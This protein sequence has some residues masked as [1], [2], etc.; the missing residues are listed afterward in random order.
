[1][2]VARQEFRVE[3]QFILTDCDGGHEGPI[4]FLQVTVLVLLVARPST[5]SV[6][7][8]VHSVCMENAVL[9]AFT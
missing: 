1:M 3:S 8:A 5:A 4:L 2:V 9:A 6:A 7:P